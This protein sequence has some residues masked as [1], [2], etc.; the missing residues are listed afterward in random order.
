MIYRV[1]DFI[2]SNINP[3]TN[4]EYGSSWMILTLSSDIDT[5]MLVGANNGCA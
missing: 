2:E 5:P 1:D 4:S 3:I